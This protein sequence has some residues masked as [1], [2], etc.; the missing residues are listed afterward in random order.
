M[1]DQQ[2]DQAA[3]SVDRQRE[4]LAATVEALA[5]KAH[6]PTRVK[7][8]AHRRRVDLQHELEQNR[9][10]VIEVTAGVAAVAVA[11]WLLRRRKARR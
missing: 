9:T 4:E 10:V 11:V 1:T 8:A 6:V 5:A 3:P 7:G 2:N